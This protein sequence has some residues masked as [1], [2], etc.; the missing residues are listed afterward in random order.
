MNQSTNAINTAAAANPANDSSPP[1]RDRHARWV[2][3][4]ITAVKGGSRYHQKMF[5]NSQI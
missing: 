4:I 1:S 5:R 3:Q 2:I